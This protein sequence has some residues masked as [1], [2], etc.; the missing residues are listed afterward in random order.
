MFTGFTYNISNSFI[1]QMY[2]GISPEMLQFLKTLN[3]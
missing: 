1:F 2:E 3:P